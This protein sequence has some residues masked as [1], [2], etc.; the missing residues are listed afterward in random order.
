M[1]FSFFKQNMKEGEKLYVLIGDK[2]HY[3]SEEIIA[4]Y[5]LKP[6]Q[7]TPFSGLEIYS[8]LEPAPVE[9]RKETKNLLNKEEASSS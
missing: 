7:K 1:A 5:F 2:K 3:L 9:E 8:S 6:G 4:R